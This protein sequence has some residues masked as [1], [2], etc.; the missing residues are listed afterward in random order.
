MSTQ[1]ARETLDTIAQRNP[2]WVSNRVL[3]NISDLVDAV[4]QTPATSS[5]GSTNAS[6][7]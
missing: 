6:T 1:Q 2:G 3:L 4:R 7:I 5:T